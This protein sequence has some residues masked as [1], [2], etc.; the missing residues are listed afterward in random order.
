MPKRYLRVKNRVWCL[1]NNVWVLYLLHYGTINERKP[2]KNFMSP[3]I[4]RPI[5]QPYFDA[6]AISDS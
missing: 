2:S 4:A 5:Y 6:R 3:L 1:P